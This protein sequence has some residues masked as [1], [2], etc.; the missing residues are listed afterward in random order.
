MTFKP[1]ELVHIDL[2]DPTQIESI[3]GKNYIFVS[4]DD[5][6]QFTWV[7]FIQEKSDTFFVFR[8]LYLKVHIEKGS[9]IICIW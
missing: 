4:I 9:K 7:N 3:G 1:L 2:I 5:F 8:A 6:S